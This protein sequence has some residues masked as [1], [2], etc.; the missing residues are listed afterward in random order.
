MTP[1]SGKKPL[2]SRLPHLLKAIGSVATALGVL[3]SALL[4]PK[5]K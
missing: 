3:A 2:G 4:D 5:S 1:K